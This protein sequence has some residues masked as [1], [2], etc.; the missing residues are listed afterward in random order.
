MGLVGPGRELV[1]RELRHRLLDVINFPTNVM[2][3]FTVRIQVGGEGMFCAEGLNQLKLHIAHVE[4]GET[5]AN[6]VENLTEQF[7]N[8]QL[9]AV[10]CERAFGI[11][12]DNGDVIDFL[13]HGVSPSARA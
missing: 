3:A 12:N 8:P 10:E 9:V 4:M 6:F 1:V 2:K 13:E 5:N 11:P 7:G